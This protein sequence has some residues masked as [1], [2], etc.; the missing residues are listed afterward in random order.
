MLTLPRRL[1]EVLEHVAGLRPY[2]EGGVRLEAEDW[3]GRWMVH[4]YG[5]G[6]AGITLAPG[7]AQLA[8]EEVLARVG[9]PARVA[10]LGAGIIGLSTARALLARGFQVTVYARELPPSTTS[11]VAGGVWAPVEVGQEGRYSELLQLSWDFYRRQASPHVVPHTA[12]FDGAALAQLEVVPPQLEMRQQDERFWSLQTLLIITAGY[13]RELAH[14]RIPRVQRTFVSRDEV[15]ALETDAWVNCLGAG[16][17]PLL[18]DAKMVP[19]RGQLVRMPPI[20]KQFT[21]IHPAGYL[22]SRPDVFLAGGTFEHGIDDP[23][24]DDAMC[25]EIVAKNQ[26][27]LDS[28][29]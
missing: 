7:S 26:A 6:G 8:A 18:G 28:F 12:Y 4:N 20:E 11:D 9:P 19:I 24:P 14:R 29:R 22:I 5:H 15:L 27:Y 21:V 1:P 17:G 3:D 2:R 16:A 13:L 10:V 25:R 23:R